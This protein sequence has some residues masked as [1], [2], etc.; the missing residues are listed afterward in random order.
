[1]QKV[2]A[3]STRVHSR[4]LAF[5]LKLLARSWRIVKILGA[6]DKNTAKILFKDFLYNVRFFS[7]VSKF[8][9]LDAVDNVT[10]YIFLFIGVLNLMATQLYVKIELRHIE[11]CKTW[12][13]HQIAD[14]SSKHLDTIRIE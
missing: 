14:E 1:M 7:K 9:Y 10:Q 4:L 12:V 5:L 3:V 6:L 2:Q 8:S 13:K 11:T